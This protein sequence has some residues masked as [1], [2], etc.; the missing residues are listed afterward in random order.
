MINIKDR[1]DCSGCSACANACPRHAV[2]MHADPMGFLYPS[3]DLNRCVDCGLCDR[4]CPFKDGHVLHSDVPVQTAYAVRAEDALTESQSGGMGWTLM[5]HIIGQG[6]IVYGVGLDE[7]FLPVHKRAA[8]I[9]GIE[10]F[11]LSKYAQSNIGRSFSQVKADL[12]AGRTVLFTGTPCQTAG[13]DSFLVES[14]KDR[15]L[16]VDIICHGTPA[17][18]MWKAY[19]DHRSERVGERVTGVRFRDPSFGWHGAKETIRFETRSESSDEYSYLFYKR[20]SVRPSCGNCHFS[21]LERPSDMTIGDCWGIEKVAPD[22]AADNKGCSL[23]LCNSVKGQDLF[24]AVKAGINVLKVDVNDVLQPNLRKS[25]S[26]SPLWK[27]VE[28]D[29]PA[30]GFE[31]VSRN[32]GRIDRTHWLTYFKERARRALRFLFARL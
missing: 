24:E 2:S 30:K 26:L 16:L 5:K 19:L 17:P 1:K 7:D 18:Q 14:L 10:E 8:D 9:A 20:V 27:R 21:K 3:I 32:Y 11:R 22:F 25:T 31:Y 23:V 6:G 12:E 29:L 13:L 15:L 28:K 4:V